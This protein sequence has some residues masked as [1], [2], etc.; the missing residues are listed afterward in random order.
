MDDP[1]PTPFLTTATTTTV[2]TLTTQP[3][4]YA[5]AVR[6]ELEQKVE[7]LK[8]IAANLMQRMTEMESAMTSTETTLQ[9]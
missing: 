8:V 6:R 9:P 4:N 3:S 7:E 2:S 1:P 5:D